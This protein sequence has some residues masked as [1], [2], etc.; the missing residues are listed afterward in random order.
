MN[1]RDFLLRQAT[2]LGA[3]AC[4]RELPAG[5]SS[6]SRTLRI[7]S[8]GAALGEGDEVRLTLL[9][10]DEAGEQEAAGVRWTSGNERVAVIDE[11]GVLRAAGP[12][13]VQVVAVAAE[14]TAWRTF[15]V[16]SA[17]S[18]LR[19]A[20]D[21]AGPAVLTHLFDSREQVRVRDGRAVEWQDLVRGL[22]A[23]ATNGGMTVDAR[24]RLLAP[25]GGFLFPPDTGFGDLDDAGTG[26]VLVS[27]PASVAPAAGQQPYAL[28]VAPAD[29]MGYP[30]ALRILPGTSIVAV[31]GAAQVASDVVPPASDAARLCT[32]LE[33]AGDRKEVLLQVGRR[34]VSHAGGEQ[35][36]AYLR[37]AP[38]TVSL[39]STP[40]THGA[41]V[42]VAAVARFRGPANAAQIQV[43][44]DYAERRYS[45]PRED[46]GVANIVFEGNSIVEGTTVL[47]AQWNPETG[48]HDLPPGDLA[49]DTFP[50]RM[51]AALGAGHVGH[52]AGTSAYNIEMLR[53]RLRWNV[54]R[55]LTHN[56]RR[57]VV[58][59][60]EYNNSFRGPAAGMAQ[61]L[62]AEWLTYVEEVRRESAGVD[63]EVR[64]IVGTMLPFTLVADL[65]SER[66]AL[67]EL[68]RTAT[69]APWDAV[70]D[71]GAHPRMGV[72]GA[73]ED[74]VIYDNTIN[75]GPSNVHPAVEGYR[76]LAQ[77]SLPVF[78]EMLA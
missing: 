38:R 56:A 10:G 77:H 20:F 41:G 45:V 31:A 69:G 43:L 2:L 23:E 30:I 75:P 78:H 9:V 50:A 33:L 18:W 59:L 61:R 64:I 63:P 51:M 44:N 57:N 27:A 32:V 8:A 60:Y 52:N 22:R 24:S 26:W 42:R 46:A 19:R 39:G 54:A 58:F 67:N 16:E 25:T 74:P 7:A 3:I 11:N 17:S 6:T 72:V 5:P 21:A 66:L 65:E 48:K 70:A 14:G 73:N 47:S 1:R 15:V 36:P 13:V 40:M 28:A 37:S 62:F 35:L 12:G 4:S 49:R 68:V 53:R 34:H 29:D 55:R 71:W 76:L